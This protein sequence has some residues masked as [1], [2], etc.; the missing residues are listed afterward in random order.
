MSF[1][2]LHYAD[3]ITRDARVFKKT[4][5]RL[6]HRELPLKRGRPNDPRL[7]AAVEMIRQGES[8]KRVLRSQIHD[9]KKMDV[10]GSYLAGKGLRTAVRRRLS[11]RAFPE[12]S[13]A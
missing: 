13:T 4:V 9:F 7:I 12:R 3:Q 8:V 6:V 2:K 11:P 5:L 1:L 10:Y